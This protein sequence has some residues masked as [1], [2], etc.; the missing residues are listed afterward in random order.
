MLGGVIVVSIIAAIMYVTGTW[1]MKRY[2]RTCPKYRY[3]YRPQP[4][5]FLEQQAEP[6]S[7]FK[8]YKDMFWKRSPWID[9]YVES[10]T[11][12]G[13]INPFVL[14]NLPTTEVGTVRESDFFFN[15]SGN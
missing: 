13:V 6:A 11:T 2:Q 4:K 3:V 15:N 10:T 7:V 12:R 14:G 5:T 9:D 1:L 8:M